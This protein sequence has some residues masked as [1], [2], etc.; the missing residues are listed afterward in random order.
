MIINIPIQLDETTFENLVKRDYENKIHDEL[1]KRIE[2]VLIAKDPGYYSKSAR[3]GL[4][5]YVK[6]VVDEHIKKYKGEIIDKAADI[7]A[8]RL[9]RTKAAKQLVKE[10][11]D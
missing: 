7:L 10:Q 3:N 2:K 8:T 1:I 11:E 9:A 4:D 5:E 6:E